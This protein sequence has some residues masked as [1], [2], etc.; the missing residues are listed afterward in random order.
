MK[1]LDSY[2]VDY[3][4]MV[5]NT[6]HLYYDRL[7]NE[8]KTPI[9]NL[10]DELKELLINK[11]IKSTLIVGTPNTIKQGL[12]RF[13]DVKT[14][15]P[16]EEEME[17]LTDSIF[18]FNKGDKKVIKDVKKICDNYLN[19]GAKTV[20]LGCTEFG[21]MLG[22]ENIPKINTIDVLVDAVIKKLSN[23][24]NSNYL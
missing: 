2:V 5:C 3:I 18:R 14:Y 21:V 4:V 24:T 10:K 8:I 22:N 9:L 19:N 15:E 6:I 1:E 17:L 7:Q 16:N 11:N 23:I 12:Y 20:I 13:E